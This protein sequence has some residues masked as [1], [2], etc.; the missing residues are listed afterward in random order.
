MSA[1]TARSTGGVILSFDLERWY[2][3]TL[4]RP[5]M[6][7]R[8]HDESLMAQSGRLLEFL[9]EQRTLA[10]F[11]VLGEVAETFPSL[12]RMIAQAG[13]EIAC[14]GNTHALLGTFDAPRFEEQL[15]IAQ[16]RLQT[17]SG[18]PVVGFRAPSWSVDAN[19]AWVFDVLMRL[20]FRYDSSIFPMRTGMYGTS[21]SPKDPYWLCH[22]GQNILEL[23]PAVGHWWGVPLPVAGGIYWRLLP[24]KLVIGTLQRGSQVHMTYAHPWELARLDPSALRP[25]PPLLRLTLTVGHR[26]PW[27]ILTALAAGKTLTALQALESCTDLPIKTLPEVLRR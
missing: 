8:Y 6:P 20:G 4:A 7:R 17:L 13:H 14:H 11:F 9:E 26:R 10:T 1:T 23:P 27:Q 15:R 2:D 16:D 24:P 3:A 18:Q 12:V 5:F 21:R 22:E 25:V 19:T